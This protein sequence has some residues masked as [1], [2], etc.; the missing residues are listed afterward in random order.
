MRLDFIACK[1][2]YFSASYYL[3]MKIFKLF[4]TPKAKIKK[5]QPIIGMSLFH[6]YFSAFNFPSLKGT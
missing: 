4:I 5:R 6:Y 3:Y 1:D 2:N